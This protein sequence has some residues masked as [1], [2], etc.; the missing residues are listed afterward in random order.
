MMMMM[1]MMMIKN[2]VVLNYSAHLENK[3]D[4][5]L[6]IRFDP[7]DLRALI[8]IIRNNNNNCYYY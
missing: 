2:R 4:T 8:I 3:A 6:Q 7:T 1:I 5:R